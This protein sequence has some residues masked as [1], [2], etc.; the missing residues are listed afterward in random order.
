MSRSRRRAATI[1]I[2][3]VPS[4][5]SVRSEISVWLRPSGSA[6]QQLGL[7]PPE[8]RE[9]GPPASAPPAGPGTPP[10]APT[11]PVEL[12]G[13]VPRLGPPPPQLVNG[14]ATGDGQD[15]GE[16][17]APLRVVVGGPLP[18]L[19]EHLLVHVFGHA[20]SP[21][22]PLRYPRTVGRI[23]GTGTP[24]SS[25][26]GARA[27]RGPGP[28]A[29]RCPAK[30]YR[31]QPPRQCEDGRSHSRVVTTGD[32]LGCRDRAGHGRARGRPQPLQAGMRGGRAT[33]RPT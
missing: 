26:H 7:L 21:S 33:C 5:I 8:P 19:E 14:P 25:G 16:Q 13:G 11:W 29:A 18:D 32:A 23:R 2:L 31:P 28:A 30:K 6:A 22:V 15:P 4:R 3:T 12:S 1:R 9:G 24:E 17:A 10:V 27:P 20:R